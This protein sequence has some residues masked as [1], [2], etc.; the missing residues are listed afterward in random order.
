MPSVGVNP[1]GLGPNQIWQ[2]D[3]THIPEFG[4]I[5]WVHVCVD[6]YS[7]YITAT[8]QTGESAKHVISHGLSAFATMGKPQEIK[9]DNGSA[10]TS[11]AFQ[12]FCRQYNIQH[13]AGIP[14]NA[15]GQAIMELSHKTLKQLLDKQRGRQT[16]L[17]SPE[18]P[19]FSPLHLKVSKL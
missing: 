15:R 6:T 9:T 5:Q 14:H 7:Q 18:M 4:K 13:K 19:P 12:S 1:H 10:Y 8:C 11:A 2:M 3:V 17:L 16:L